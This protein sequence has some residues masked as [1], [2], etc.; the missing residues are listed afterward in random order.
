MDGAIE[1]PMDGFTG[2][3]RPCLPSPRLGIKKL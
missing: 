1:P 3:S 2:V